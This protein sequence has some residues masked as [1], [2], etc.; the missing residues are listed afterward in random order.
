VYRDFTGRGEHSL[1][2]L[3]H[4]ISSFLAPVFFVLMG[5]HTDLRAFAQPGVAGLAAG[6]TVAAVAGKQLAGSGVMGRGVDRIMVGL[7]MM[8][9]GEVGLIFANIGVALMV[10][11][12]R[13]VTSA[14]FAAIVVMVVIT[15]L[16]TPPALRWRLARIAG[17]ADRESRGVL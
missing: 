14:I 7:G 15:T 12:E 16:L 13:I 4:P 6:L 10:G 5:M 11:G 17:P 3:V 2:E 1:E 8:P 9:R